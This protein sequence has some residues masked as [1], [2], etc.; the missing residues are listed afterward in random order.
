[1]SIINRACAYYDT[2]K[3]FQDLHSAPPRCSTEGFS[4][5]IDDANL[6]VMFLSSI[7]SSSV[8]VRIYGQEKF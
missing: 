5:F 4:I 2:E 1:V 6:Q 8:R 3:C 7:S